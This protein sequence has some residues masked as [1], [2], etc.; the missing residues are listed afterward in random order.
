MAAIGGLATA[1]AVAAELAG[2]VV[3][4]AQQERLFAE[5]CRGAN[6]LQDRALQQ[7]HRTFS[8]QQR[9]EAALH[10]RRMALSKELHLNEMTHATAVARREAVRD[11]WSQKNQ[12]IQ[13]LMVV[14]TVMFACAFSLAVEATAPETTDPV[15]LR[16]YS[17]ATAV[18]LGFLFV[19]I[20]LA[21][22]LQARMSAYDMHRQDRQYGCGRKHSEFPEFFECHC[23]RLEMGTFV[24]F[25][26]GTVATVASGALYVTSVLLW[27]LP[28]RFFAPAWLFV[29]LC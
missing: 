23:E 28:L 22:K 5:Q 13:T 10:R 26:L 12:L 19:S 25:W 16:C 8:E 9:F 11:V 29:A 15:T 2:L 27:G 17:G 1:A 4:Y 24:T 18:S 20:W 14:D 21:L 6:A 7:Q 3:P